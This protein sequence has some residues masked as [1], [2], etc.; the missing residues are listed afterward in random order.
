[1]VFFAARKRISPLVL[2]L[3]VIALSPFVAW[4]SRFLRARS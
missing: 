4:A 1:M 3:L 2:V